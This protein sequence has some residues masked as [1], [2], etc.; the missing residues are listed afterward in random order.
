MKF[1]AGRAVR[2]WQRKTPAHAQETLSLLNRMLADERFGT[3][4]QCIKHCGGLAKGN[5]VF[6]LL[7]DF[8]IE[9]QSPQTGNTYGGKA[10]Q[11]EMLR[12]FC[13]RVAGRYPEDIVRD[14]TQ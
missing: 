1:I 7:Q 8:K 11:T 12:V 4:L 10:E 9:P 14:I 6:V 2:R 13:L 5:D 3:L